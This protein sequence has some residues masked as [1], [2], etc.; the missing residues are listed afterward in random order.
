M[1]NCCESDKES[2]GMKKCSLCQMMAMFMVIAA[3][4]ILG[5]KFLGH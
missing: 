4:I 3:I 2:G 1:G 5:I